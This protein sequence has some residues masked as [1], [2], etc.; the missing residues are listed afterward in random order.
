MD[1]RHPESEAPGPLPR[2]D[3]EPSPPLEEAWAHE[4]TQPGGRDPSDDPEHQRLLARHEKA[5]DVR[6]DARE[7][8]IVDRLASV[9][10]RCVREGVESAVQPLRRQLEEVRKENDALRGALR[11]M[12]DTLERQT[13]V[14]RRWADNSAVSVTRAD[15]LE[16]RV[17]ARE[18]YCAT[19]HGNGANLPPNGTG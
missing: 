2:R 6:W 5:E 4:D 12:S 10:A 16:Q 3:T 14:M 13:E 7:Q 1:A 15:Q 11:L 18:H 17:E 9:V 8:A 19:Q